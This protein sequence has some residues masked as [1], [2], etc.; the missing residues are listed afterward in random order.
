MLQPDAPHHGRGRGVKP[1]RALPPQ[2][3]HG[4]EC[5]RLQEVKLDMGLRQFTIGEQER[6]IV[7]YSLIQQPYHFAHILGDATRWWR[8]QLLGSQV[9]IVRDKVGRRRLFNCG[10]LRR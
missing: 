9:T 4:R 6:W 8:P 7:C 2:A 10:F 3:P 1:R 5:D